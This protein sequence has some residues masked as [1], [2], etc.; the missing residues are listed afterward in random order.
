MYRIAVDTVHAVV[1]VTLSG[2]MTVEEGAAYINDLRRA[3]VV[4]RLR[5]GY[6]MVIDVSECPI[7]QQ[8]IIQTMRAHMA[9]MPKARA[10][11]IV[12]GSSLARMQVRR[13]F[14]QSYARIAA[15]ID[16]G[17]A[18]VINGVEPLVDRPVVA[19]A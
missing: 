18:W 15:S 5:Y 14:T 10:L 8:D 13:L 3:L 1:E 9:E 12:T 16:E 6:A 7:Q 11:A 17:R 2:M 4:N 19:I